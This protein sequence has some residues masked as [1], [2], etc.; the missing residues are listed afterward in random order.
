MK[1]NYSVSGHVDGWCTK[2]KLELG[3]TII[4]LANNLPVKVKCNT[5][6][7]EGFIIEYI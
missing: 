2:C 3:H 4:A 6:E 1:N 5:C 7:G